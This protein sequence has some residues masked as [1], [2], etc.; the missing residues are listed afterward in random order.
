MR[1]LKFLLDLIRGIDAPTESESLRDGVLSHATE[2]HALIIG[3]GAGFVAELMQQP[4]LAAAVIALAFGAGSVDWA[5]QYLSKEV[6][7]ELRQEPWYAVGGVLAG[8]VVGVLV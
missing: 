8:Y 5:R 6:E 2:Y 7:T 4:V 1:P 3:L